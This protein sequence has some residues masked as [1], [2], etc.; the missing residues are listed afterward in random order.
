MR[1]FVLI[2]LLFLV[3]VMHSCRSSYS[4]LQPAEG[5]ARVLDTFRPRFARVLYTTQVDVVGNHLSGF[6]LIKTMPDS[7]LRLVFS[8][9]MGLK[10]FD[11]EFYRDGGFKVHHIIK[12]MDRKAVI[13]TLRN[14]FELVLMRGLDSSNVKIFSDDRLLYYRFA[15]K[16]GYNYYITSKDGSQLIRMERSSKRK[17]V[18]IAVMSN[19]TAKVPDTIG[20]THKNF[21][22][23]IGLKR[24]DN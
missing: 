6:L 22:F 4:H 5:N 18:A 12:K 1:Y 20:I 15:Q 21:N 8:N 24:T 7:S 2:N 17:P 16:K 19:Y 10:F 3:A 14:D 13:K 11:F 9:E 23:E